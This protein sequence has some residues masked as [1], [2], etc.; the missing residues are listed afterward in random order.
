MFDILKE[1]YAKS[2]AFIDRLT[3]TMTTPADIESIGILVS[4]IYEIAYLK[5]VQDHKDALMER[6]L[7]ATIRPQYPQQFIDEHSIFPK[8]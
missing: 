5:A 2:Q 7:K 3:S 1:R 4:D 8:T 6:G